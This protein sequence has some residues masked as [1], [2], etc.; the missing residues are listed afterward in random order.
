MNSNEFVS[1]LTAHNFRCNVVVISIFRNSLTCNRF[2][3]LQM[4]FF[5]INGETEIGRNR[6]RKEFLLVVRC[7]KR[8]IENS[9]KKETGA[10]EVETE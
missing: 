2:V 3:S 7:K 1:L 10:T 9:K 4:E 5:L 8:K 6:R